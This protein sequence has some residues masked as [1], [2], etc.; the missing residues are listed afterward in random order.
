MAKRATASECREVLSRFPNKGIS[1]IGRDSQFQARVKF[2]NGDST[3]VMMVITS[4]ECTTEMEAI[5]KLVTFL[6]TDE[7]YFP[8]AKLYLNEP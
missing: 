7:G 3:R 4:T 1:M 8:L 5:I 2:T 6:Y